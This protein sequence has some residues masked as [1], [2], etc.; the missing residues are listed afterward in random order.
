MKA[1]IV[2]R[3]RNTNLPKAKA[4]LPLFESV[5]NAFQAIEEAGGKGHYI[6]ITAERRGSLDDSKPGPI[7][8]FTVT[9]SGIGFTDANFD[10]FV[11]VDSPYKAPSGGKGLGRFLWLKAFSRVEIESHYR[12]GPDE[13]LCRRFSFV[14][15]DA[16]ILCAPTK[17]ERRTPETT[18]R[19]IGYRAPY[20]DECP[21]QVDIIAQRLIGHFLPM[22]LDSEGPKLSIDQIDLRAFFREN[23][24]AFA[25]RRNFTVGDQQF[26]LS[27]F[28]MRGALADHHELVYAAHFRE[29]ITERLSKFIP[30]LKNRLEEPDNSTFYYLAFIQ[31]EF[32]D[33]KVNA[34][35]TDFSIPRDPAPI[36]PSDADQPPEPPESDAKPD[37]FAGE[38]SL[39]SIRDAALTK[40]REDLGPFLNQ[41]NIQ[42]EAALPLAV[43]PR[44]L[45]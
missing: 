29:V 15:N 27:G 36:K 4:L 26:S 8:S 24:Q 35:R 7:E 9:D 10:S 20:I 43:A 11:T 12:A 19:L 34:E 2:G 42:K 14:Q 25:T 23:F 30:N 45:P 16:D 22:F 41:I 39:H 32:L 31:G 44:P 1:S 33:E 38:I 13:L 21:R 3:I 18:I 37:L 40:V 6:R 5:M 28:R 17:S